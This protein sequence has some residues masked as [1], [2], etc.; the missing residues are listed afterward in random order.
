MIM[1]RK[2]TNQWLQNEIHGTGKLY[3]LHG[4]KEPQ[5]NNLPPAHVS[6]LVYA[7]PWLAGSNQVQLLLSVGEHENALD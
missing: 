5:K 4:R 7:P 1:V 2:D 3:L 6:R